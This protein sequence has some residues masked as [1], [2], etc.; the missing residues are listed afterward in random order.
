[1]AVTEKYFIDAGYKR[2]NPNGYKNADFGLQ[3]LI[4]D[5][6]GKKYYLTVFAYDWT[7]YPHHVG[8]PISFMPEV[9]F[10]INQRTPQ[11]HFFDVS[12]GM[13]AETTIEV[14]ETEY[15]TLWMHFGKPYY[16]EWDK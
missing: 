3:K 7:K 1:M 16:E 12:M 13:G 2:F 15:E 14:I 10:R 6:Q 5:E 11:E 9:Q 4:S 8:E